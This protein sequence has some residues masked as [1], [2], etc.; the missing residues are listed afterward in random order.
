MSTLRKP[1]DLPPEP[2]DDV[3]RYG[4]RDRYEKDER[5]RVR[6]VRI[7]LT[8]ED[9]LHPQEGDKIV[10]NDPHFTD[11][12]Y[13]VT[14]LRALLADRP[15]ALVLSDCSIIWDI[16]ALRNHGPDVA[17]I[18]GVRPRRVWMSFDVAEEGVRPV[19]IIEVT[20]P[21]TRDTDLG[22]QVQQYYQAG[23]AFYVV[24]D[25][26]IDRDNVRHLELI[27]YERGARRYRRMR[28]NARGRLWLPPVGP[29]LGQENDRVALYTKRGRR[30]EDYAEVEQGRQ[31]AEERAAAAEERVRQ[32][33]EELRRRGQEPT[34]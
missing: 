20:S 32:L 5:G 26:T 14:V 12:V 15:D 10:Q 31:A 33:E 4:W 23:V 7:P 1:T 27:G 13:L 16:R 25:A 3:F 24:V 9:V 17:V 28:P 21:A 22:E 29:W 34:P 30:L 18:F 11:V 19:L 6:F 2:A 8:R